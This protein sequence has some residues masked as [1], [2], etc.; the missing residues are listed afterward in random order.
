MSSD[1]GLMLECPLVPQG[2]ADDYRVMTMTMGFHEVFGLERFHALVEVGPLPDNI[3]RMQLKALLGQV[4]ARARA[5][6]RRLTPA[7]R[8]RRTSG[9]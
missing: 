4:R 2:T 1:Y 7:R 5:A 9:A 6:P 8:R 3:R